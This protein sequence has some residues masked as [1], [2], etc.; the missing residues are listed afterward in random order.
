MQVNGQVFSVPFAYSDLAALGWA[1]REGFALS[2]A[3]NQT[4][5]EK[6]SLGGQEMYARFVNTGMDM[7]SYESCN[8]GGFIV[9]GY[10]AGKGVQF[11][12]PQGI[13][14]GSSYDQ[15]VAAYGAPTREN[16]TETLRFMD[17]SADSYAQVSFQLDLATQQVKKI[18]VK[19][20]F[21]AM[22]AADPAAAPAMGAASA[23]PVS[24]DAVGRYQA[25]GELSASWQDFTL[26]YGGALYRLPAPVQVFVANGWVVQSDA[27]ETVA[28]RR[29]KVGV[30]LRLENQVLRTTVR[31]YDD[32]GQPVGNC[33]VTRVK[34][35]VYGPSVPLELP[36]GVTEGSTIEQIIAVYGQPTS[37]STSATFDHYTFGPI[38]ERI[39]ISYD[40]Q[41]AQISTIEVDHDPS[42]LS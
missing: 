22:P 5:M 15:V 4:T 25:P 13:T 33:Y 27:N 10:D 12:L 32:T 6:L 17:Y 30:E 1:P 3:P 16:Q 31:N 9:D 41:K 38:G 29:A 2:L 39:E 7:L 11:V 19:N 14:I 36:Q 34:S 40:R 37:S 42:T 24:S 8:V 20:Y 23:Q 26:R 18:D 28:A 35:S 21:G